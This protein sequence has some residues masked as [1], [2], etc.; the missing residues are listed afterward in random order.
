MRPPELVLG[1]TPNGYVGFSIVSSI[2]N[3]DNMAVVP[4]RANRVLNQNEPI[5]EYVVKAI[6]SS[7]TKK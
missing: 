6:N 5:A 7:A 1:A 4:E 2:R 3:T